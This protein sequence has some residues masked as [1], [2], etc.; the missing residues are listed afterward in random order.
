M[1]DNQI[2]EFELVLYEF[3]TR[4]ANKNATAEEVEA[5]P[6]VAAVLAGLHSEFSAN[7]S[8]KPS[9]IFF[10][11]SSFNIP[12]APCRTFSGTQSLLSLSA[13]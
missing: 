11:F 2:K 3:V 4:A 6:A 13:K 5:L 12:F 1:T 8:R 9:N 10:T 7:I